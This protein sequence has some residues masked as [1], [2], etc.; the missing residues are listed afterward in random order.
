MKSCI[1]LRTLLCLFTNHFL[2]RNEKTS[3]LAFFE[4]FSQK[5][6]QFCVEKDSVQV[7]SSAKRSFRQ[8]QQQ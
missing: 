3:E 5:H 8:L 1:F 6:Y 4:N 2:W 7:F